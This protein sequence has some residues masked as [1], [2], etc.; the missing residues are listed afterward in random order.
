MKIISLQYIKEGFSRIKRLIGETLTSTV[1]AITEVESKI[2]K[3]V[4]QLE[5]DTGF[6]TNSEANT[7]YTIS[8]SGAT[9]TLTGSD[10][11]EDS[12][13]FT[14]SDIGLGNVP[15]VSTNNQ[16]PTFTLAAKRE[17]IES[18][19]TLTVIMGKIMKFFSDL[20]D[21][22]FTG[23]YNDLTNKPTLFSGSYSDLSN[24]PSI[25]AAAKN[26]KLTISKNGGTV[27]TF[28]A[29]QSTAATADITV[30][31][32]VSQLTND[33]GFYN[34]SSPP[35]YPVT[36]VNGKTGTVTLA[37]SDVNAV[38]SSS[39]VQNSATADGYVAKSGGTSN[40]NK[41][42][43]TDSSGVPGWRADAD[44][45]YKD[46]VGAT[47]SAAGKHGLVPVPPS[48]GYNTKY[49]RADGQWVKPPDT[50]T[51]YTNASL[52]QGYGTCT[53]EA[54]ITT[55]VVTLS[56]YALTVGGVVSVKFTYA[57][58]ANATMN[59]NSKGAKPIYYKGAAI[60]ANI[61]K[62][63][64][65]ATFI[66][67][68]SQYH[69][70]SIDNRIPLADTATTA[71]TATTANKVKAALTFTGGV[72]KTYDG[73]TAQSVAIPIIPTSIKNPKALNFTG[74]LSASYDGSSALT[75][76]IPTKLP[77]NGGNADTVDGYHVCG[78]S[79]NAGVW[80]KI[81]RVGL[82]GVMEVGKYIDFH[83]SDNGAD[84]DSRLYSE[85][86]RLNTT[87][88][89][90]ILNAEAGL[91]IGY[92]AF[93]VSAGYDLRF[94]SQYPNYNPAQLLFQGGTPT[95]Q[96][97]PNTNGECRLGLGQYRFG[98][99]YTSVSVSVTSDRTKKD[100]ITPLKDSKYIELFKLL[101]PVSYTFIDGTSGRTHIGFVS[102][103]VEEAMEKLGMTSLDF[104]GF[105]KDVVTKMVDIKDEDGKIIGT[106]F[107]P[108]LD[109]EGNEQ[110]I[111]SLRYEEFIALNTAMIQEQQDE[112]EKM[113]GD[114]LML[115]QQVELLMNG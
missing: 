90:H 32:K 26:G 94:N 28:T 23:N 61:I 91:M 24:K 84:Y 68:G 37:A 44:T 46:M 53:T 36:K 14:K 12:E 15:N 69:L 16:S 87:L 63:G 110:Y 108:V 1:E 49:L 92:K 71:T 43:K 78:S 99:I 86:G 5:N 51:T 59:V 80:G 73:S 103:D 35:P 101:S 64:D 100:N 113:K 83:E 3:K 81:T 112:I 6:I 2:P 17:N 29:D 97:F 9:I 10:G 22:A 70:V 58:P 77:A 76:N 105:C 96:F 55:K 42:W 72:S 21:V 67:N 115:K 56:S 93:I 31:T 79:S 41:V 45:T 95:P 60:T 38:P 50:N 13:T 98:Q 65:T 109:D 11:S 85:G 102:Q 4:S 25:P 106:N 62:A 107:D 74:S 19:N 75:V 34:S 114:I 8:K 82:D 47:A 89:I 57:V 111:Y 88:G 7:T 52:G 27:A 40:A 18:G 33:S 104:A 66:Y 54:A 39:W 48:D 20:K 30:P